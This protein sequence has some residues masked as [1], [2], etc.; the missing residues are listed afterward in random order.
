MNR[1]YE[2]MLV[3]RPTVEATDE[4]TQDALIAKLLT[5]QQLKVK[6]TVQGKKELSYPIQKLTEGLYVLV[7]L[8][9]KAVDANAI[10]TSARVSENLLRY[11]LKRID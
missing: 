6:K 8:E 7:E 9:G 10:A 3:L 1:K 2:L 4:K 11:L 5:G